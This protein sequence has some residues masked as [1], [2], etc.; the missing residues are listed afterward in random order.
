MGFH[1]RKS[2]SIWG[3]A[4]STVEKHLI[5]GVELC[6]RFIQERTGGAS[7]RLE[8]AELPQNRRA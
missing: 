2:R 7:E 1:I 3:I 8:R 6:E 5:K 4:V